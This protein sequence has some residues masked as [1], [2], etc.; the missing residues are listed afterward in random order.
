MRTIYE[1]VNG[2]PRLSV[3]YRVTFVLGI[4]WVGH[5]IIRYLLGEDDQLL[6]TD[7]VWS[8]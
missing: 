7:Y 3:L 6:T 4:R 5:V 1:V 2:D 8:L